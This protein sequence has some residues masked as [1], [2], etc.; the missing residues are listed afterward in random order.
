MAARL[1]EIAQLSLKLIPEKSADPEQRSS[2][3]L[4]SNTGAVTAMGQAA[5][6]RG[7]LIHRVSIQNNQITDYQI[8]AP[9][10]WNFH[11]DG[12]VAGA[13]AHIQ[14]NADNSKTF[15]HEQQAHLII[16]AIDPCVDYQLEIEA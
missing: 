4:H 5:A 16:K 9:T 1:T 3:S 10:E 15:N 13:L 14:G 11:P 8:L 2:D 12:V 6:A 7:Q